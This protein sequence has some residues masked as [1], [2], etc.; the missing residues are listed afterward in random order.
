MSFWCKHSSTTV[1]SLPNIGTDDDEYRV[2]RSKGTGNGLRC[3]HRQS[4]SDIFRI[5][6]CCPALPTSYARVLLRV[7][8][9]RLHTKL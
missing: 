5:V 2:R 3:A 6:V 7:P 9:K 4:S 8:Y 1:K